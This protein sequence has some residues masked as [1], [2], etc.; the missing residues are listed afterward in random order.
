MRVPPSVGWMILLLTI[1]GCMPVSTSGSSTRPDP[2]LSSAAPVVVVGPPKTITIGVTNTVAGFGPWNL[3]AASGGAKSIAEASAAALVAVDAD[4]NRTPWLAM[5]LPSLADGSITTLPDGKIQMTW[6]LRPDVKWHDGAPFTSADLVLGWRIM[7]DPQLPLSQ[8]PV[9]PLIESIETPDPLTAIMTWKSVYYQAVSIGYTELFPLPVHLLGDLYQR[10]DSQALVGSPYWTSEFVHL[11]AYRVVDFQIGERT[12]LERMDSYFLGQPK[13]KTIV[14]RVIPDP[15]TLLA[16][17][18]AGAVD[19]AAEASLPREA[20]GV[21]NQAWG[22]EGGTIVRRVGR[23]AVVSFQFNADWARPIELSRDPRLRRGLYFGLDRESI[24]EVGLGEAR[25][26]G[27]DDPV[28]MGSFMARGDP[29]AAAVGTPFA[30]YRYDPTRAVRELNDGGWRQI[31]G[32]LV[33]ERGEGV[34]LPFRT[35]VDAQN[36]LAVA[37]KYWRDLGLEVAEDVVPGPL[38]SN[39]EYRSQ[40]PATELNFRGRG[41]DGSWRFFH[42]SQIPTPENRFGGVNRGSYRHAT[43][44]RLIDSLYNSLDEREQGTLLRQ[45]GEIAAADLPFLPLYFDVDFAAIAKGTRVVTNNYVSS[46]VAHQWD[47]D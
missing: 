42:G 2:G 22:R 28:T 18:L 38:V 47:R 4:G 24:S 40:F 36:A 7:G 41:G 23:F 12:I 11:G 45:I 20:V 13:V 14:V 44:D 34:Q 5:K 10:A 3:G 16:N 35:E 9:I 27:N 43:F 26:S 29:R 19:F 32:R 31:G 8:S 39:R 46:N 25:L 37:A 17:V 1:A 30:E 15:N 21:L 33:N 6:H